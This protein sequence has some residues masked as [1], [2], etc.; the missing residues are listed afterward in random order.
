LTLINTDKLPA[1]RFAFGGEF[2]NKRKKRKD[3]AFLFFHRASTLKIGKDCNSQTVNIKNIK[4]SPKINLETCSP[5]CFGFLAAK[6]IATREMTTIIMSV[7]S[8]QKDGDGIIINGLSL[9]FFD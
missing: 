2:C 5:N 9:I 4:S 7:T 8:A 6:P 1:K 3:S